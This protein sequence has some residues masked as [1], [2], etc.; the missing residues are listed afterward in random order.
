[1]DNIG[2]LAVVKDSTWHK[3]SAGRSDYHAW[4][5]SPQQLASKRL[6]G[7][8]PRD[9][10]SRDKIKDSSTVK[11]G[12]LYLDP[13]ARLPSVLIRIYCAQLRRFKELIKL[14]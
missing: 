9:F 6:L 5:Q 12:N 4:G 1:M 8:E 7:D 13:C 2:L 14:K 10:E 11:L 3:T